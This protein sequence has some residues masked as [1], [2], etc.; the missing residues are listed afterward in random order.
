MASNE[1]K[2]NYI[3]ILQEYYSLPCYTK[4]PGHLTLAIPSQ[5][6]SVSVQLCFLCLALAFSQ[7]LLLVLLFF[8]L[9][10]MISLLEGS[11]DASSKKLSDTCRAA[12]IVSP[13]CRLY[14]EMS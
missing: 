6:K 7:P 1:I 11:V 12:C 2:N 5:D 3:V 4:E 10:L 9:G 13:V 14:P 8:S